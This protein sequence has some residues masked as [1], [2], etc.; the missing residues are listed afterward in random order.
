MEDAASGVKFEIYAEE[1]GGQV[2]FTIKHITGNADIQGFFVDLGNDGG[3]ITSVGSKSNNMNGSSNDGTKLDGWDYGTALGTV[4]GSDANYTTPNTEKSFTIAGITSLAQ[5]DGAQLGIRATSTGA[6]GQGSLKLADVVE[7]P[8]PPP[9]IDHFP[10]RTQDIS[11]VDFYM[12]KDGDG[13]VDV[14]VRVNTSAA[15]NDDLDTWYQTALNFIK[16]A[17]LTGDGVGNDLQNAVL[18]GVAIKGGSQEAKVFYELDG[19][20]NDV[21]PLPT[22]GILVDNPVGFGGHGLGAYNAVI[23]YD[24]TTFQVGTAWSGQDYLG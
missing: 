15:V 7:L 24:G 12:D 21:D 19:N 2:V 22:H 3:A 6:D 9:P 17:D 10:P 16:S 8:P 23:S 13:D 5:L 4:G 20:P 11:H 14:Y 1:V 18:L